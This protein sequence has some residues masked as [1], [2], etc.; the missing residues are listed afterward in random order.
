[1]LVDWLYTSPTWLSSIVIMVVA[2]VLAIGVLLIAHSIISVE[3]RRQ[4]NDLTGFVIAVVGVVYAVLLAFIAV[5]TWESYTRADEIAVEEATYAGNLYRDSVGLPEQI[6]G[7]LRTDLR[8]YIEDVIKQEW[9]VQ[10]AGNVPGTGWPMLEDMQI[11]IARFEPQTAGQTV[12]Q[13]EWLHTLNQLYAARRHRL[14]AA[15]GHVPA[16]GWWVI[17]L[18]GLVTIGCTYLFGADRLPMQMILTAAVT[19]I[20]TLNVILIVQLDY[21]FRGAVS[22]SSE[23]YERVLYNMDHMASQVELSSP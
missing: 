16:I 21:P 12:V 7:P 10:R 19:A 17:V 13:Q 8:R 23:A 2:E 9:P 22:V 20:L 6:A 14:L 5:V 11:R 15:Q 3:F 1:M 4:H 18:G